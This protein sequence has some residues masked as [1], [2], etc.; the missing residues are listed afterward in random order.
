MKKGSRL[1]AVFTY[2]S[3]ISPVIHQADNIA[4]VYCNIFIK[5]IS[6][7]IQNVVIICLY[8]VSPWNITAC[9]C[10]FHLITGFFYLLT[11]ILRKRVRGLSSEEIVPIFHQANKGKSSVFFAINWSIVEWRFTPIYHIHTPRF[12]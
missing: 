2:I 9:P 6:W 8:I 5:K 1:R 12:V 4:S 7:H 3:N 11:L 10:Q